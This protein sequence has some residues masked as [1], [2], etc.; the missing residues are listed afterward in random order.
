MASVSALWHYAGAKQ[1]S[2]RGSEGKG[3]RPMARIISL[4]LVINLLVMAT[5]DLLGTTTRR[6]LAAAGALIAL[7]GVYSTARFIWIRHHEET[8]GV[9]APATPERRELRARPQEVSS[10]PG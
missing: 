5:T 4:M 1:W 3:D 2:T 6:L 8:P 9:S 10:R 7:N